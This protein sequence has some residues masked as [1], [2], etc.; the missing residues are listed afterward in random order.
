MAA[1]TSTVVKQ[2]LDLITEATMSCHV[3]PRWDV[4]LQLCDLCKLVFFIKVI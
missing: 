3:T 1:S 4:I 2:A